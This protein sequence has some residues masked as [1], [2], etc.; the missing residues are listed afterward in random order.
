[1]PNRAI[2]VK[3]EARDDSFCQPLNVKLFDMFKG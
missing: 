3:L 2:I 1:M